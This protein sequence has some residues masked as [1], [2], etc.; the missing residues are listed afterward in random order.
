MYQGNTALSLEPW[1]EKP[2]ANDACVSGVR[3]LTRDPIGLIGGINVYQYAYANP[4]KYIDPDGQLGLP[5]AIILGVLV[6]LAYDAFTDLSAD[7]EAGNNAMKDIMDARESGDPQ[8]IQDAAK[9]LN[10][11]QNQ[12]V[13]DVAGATDIRQKLNQRPFGLLDDYLEG[14]K[15]KERDKKCP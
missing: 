11:A 13:E 15:K 9:N 6:A 12:I 7:V 8:A 1:W 2:A 10:D 4:L 14:Q 5:S 3:Y